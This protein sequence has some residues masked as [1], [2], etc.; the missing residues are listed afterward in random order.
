MM[1]YLRVAIFTLLILLCGLFVFMFTTFNAEHEVK[2]AL[3]AYLK[4]DLSKA[5][6]VLSKL[7]RQLPESKY[8][9]LQSYIH[10]EEG[11]L[12]EA[13]R[14]LELAYDTHDKKRPD[15]LLLEI[16]VNQCVVAFRMENYQ[17]LST[18]TR[19]AEKKYHSKEWIQFFKGLDHYYNKQ[20]YGSSIQLITSSKRKTHFNPWMKKSL[21]HV[22]DSLWEETL[23]AHCQVETGNYL[24]ARQTLGNQT[25]RANAKQLEQIYLLLGMSYIKE[26]QGKP[27]ELVLP[28][29]KLA[30]S[31]LEKLPLSSSLL[32]NEKTNILTV[33]KGT[34]NEIVQK[35]R[36]DLLPFY[37][38]ILEKWKDF[39]T[40]NNLSNLLITK[41]N[42]SLKEEKWGQAES[43]AKML[44]QML[45]STEGRKILSGRF[46]EKIQSLIEEDDIKY[47]PR[48]WQIAQF[49][50]PA[51]EDF[52]NEMSMLFEKKIFEELGSDDINLSA[53][54]TNL[55]IWKEISN[56][57]DQRLAIAKRMLDVARSHWVI[58]GQEKKA[59]N[60]LN[61]ASNLPVVADKGKINKNIKECVETLYLTLLHD[62]QID[63]LPLLLAANKQFQL[64]SEV[65]YNEATIKEQYEKAKK[66]FN[67]DDLKSA[68]KHLKWILTLSPG[69]QEA[70][71]LAAG[72]D[73]QLEDYPMALK[74]MNKLKTLPGYIEEPFAISL[75]LSKQYLV[76]YKKIRIL[77]VRNPLKQESVLK[78]GLGFIKKE[79]WGEAANWLAKL[80]EDHMEAK[81]ALAYV[82]A[83][84]E[85]WAQARGYLEDLEPAYSQTTHVKALMAFVKMND[86]A[87]TSQ[88]LDSL[89]SDMLSSTRSSEEPAYSRTYGIFLD[90]NLSQMDP[91]Y[92]AAIYYR[93][94][95][96]D[97]KS[98]EHYINEI[99]LPISEVLIEKGRLLIDASRL[100]EASEVLGRVIQ[101]SDDNQ[102]KSAA[103]LLLASIQASSGD[104]IVTKKNLEMQ[105][106]DNPDN[107]NTRSAY[108][109]ALMELR[110]FQEAMNQLIHLRNESAS[111][112]KYHSTYIQCLVHNGHVDEA[113][114]QAKAWIYKKTPLSIGEQLRIARILIKLEV[115]MIANEII[116]KV[117]DPNKLS[118]EDKIV[119]LNLLVD[120][121]LYEPALEFAESDKENLSQSEEGLDL[122][123]RLYVNLSYYGKAFEL[124]KE[125]QTKAIALNYEDEF[126][127]LIKKDPE[128][129]KKRFYDLKKYRK[130]SIK[131]ISNLLFYV[132]K[133]T[134]LAPY[135]KGADA[136]PKGYLK[137]EL[138]EAYYLLQ[139]MGEEHS[140]LP[141]VQYLLGSLKGLLDENENA[142]QLY[143]KALQLDP[144]Y[145]EAYKKLGIIYRN[146]G[147]LSKSIY[148]FKQATKYANDDAESW[149]ELG[150]L[151]SSVQDMF[152]A[153]LAFANAVQLKPNESMG[154]I[155]L[156]QVLMLLKNPEDAKLALIQAVKLDGTSIVAHELLLLCL[157]DKIL[158]SNEEDPE[159][160]KILQSQVYQRLYDLDSERAK[161]IA[162]RLRIDAE[163]LYEQPNLI[164]N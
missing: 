125:T 10:Q 29:H 75:T 27:A 150:K 50:H 134:N 64:E 149:F 77:E 49:F 34:V 106:N 41:I 32:Q 104:I 36:Y 123:K 70:R 58:D 109:M 68:R 93:D 140:E 82:A 161:R 132:R 159:G 121:K 6:Q 142:I 111:V 65:I 39:E 138:H 22:F 38:V 43:I 7:N 87:V 122:L 144:S 3:D 120:G 51:P 66:Y 110:L 141:E 54:T 31:Y 155:A 80:P 115:P 137:D 105:L 42:T 44:S 2:L 126:L 46:R 160:I 100:E 162:Q 86:E 96:N 62:D 52:R 131:N 1:Q 127:F 97:K 136:L 98:Y 114:K 79:Y 152:E 40:L 107:V 53:T 84:Q 128:Q 88:D 129:L 19:E 143:V 12:H 112:S 60:I 63:K 154:Y 113:I 124:V 33:I 118:V 117:R 18:I 35:E 15:M 156:G 25:K 99:S 148:S 135:T 45:R 67:D 145:S 108:V 20:E 9:L 78:L 94:V 4:G 146:Q 92:V 24:S 14:E 133:L 163:A 130:E 95:K 102:T 73:Y 71:M 74:H 11:S 157:Y 55:R 28:Y 101:S 59:F 37:S 116:K 5:E 8:H 164:R 91:S 23:T 13:S 21:K 89:I 158:I 85:N 30:F 90:R 147:V 76:G 16:Y 56:N 83:M 26:S 119:F 17:Q 48:Y 57:S 61:S 69:N 72:V 47:L 153:K 103:T 81:V 139:K 151:Y